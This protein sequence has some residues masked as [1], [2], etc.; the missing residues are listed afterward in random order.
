MTPTSQ[1]P[2]QA[3]SPA[4]G[5]SGL[6]TRV[7]I[8]T[9]LPI[10]MQLTLRA[11]V[12]K[13]GVVRSPRGHRAG[14]RCVWFSQS[15]GRACSWPLLGGGHG[16]ITHRTGAP[17]ELPSPKHPESKDRGALLWAETVDQMNEEN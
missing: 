4:G 6:D 13:A 1:A 5:G 11:V 14:W 16:L 17:R 7:N 9:E 8:Q 10:L 2:S 15:W 3:P 12:L